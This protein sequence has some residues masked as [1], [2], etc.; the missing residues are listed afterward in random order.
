MS[1]LLNAAAAEGLLTNRE[2]GLI[3][4]PA[5]GLVRMALSWSGVEG[6]DA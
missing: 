4:T 2:F 3:I 1:T 5:E 6:L